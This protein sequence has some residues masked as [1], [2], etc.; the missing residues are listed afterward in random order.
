MYAVRVI[1]VSST[2]LISSIP[3][4]TTGALTMTLPSGVLS[5]K[6]R[7]AVS[8]KVAPGIRSFTPTSGKRGSTVTLSGTNLAG[9]T[10]V[11]IGGVSARFTVRSGTS[12]VLT[13]PLTARSGR[14]VI[15]TAGG[16]ATSLASYRVL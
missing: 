2:T 9:V 10:R 15:T 8:G 4:T 5:V 16:S 14:I 1:V 6:S 12:L 3:A 11:M 13:V 7:F